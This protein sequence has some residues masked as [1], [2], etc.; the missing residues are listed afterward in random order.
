MVGL[1]PPGQ[2]RS[3]IV[4]ATPAGQCEHCRRT[5]ES[6]GA[7]QHSPM[8]QAATRPGTAR[9]QYFGL[10]DEGWRA[11]QEGSEQGGLIPEPMAL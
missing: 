11:L 9:L 2:R 3:R 1:G 7:D 4:L 6:F 10:P 5:R 8:G